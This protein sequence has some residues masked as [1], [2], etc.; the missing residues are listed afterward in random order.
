MARRA[1][2]LR[3]SQRRKLL[4]DKMRVF[5]TGCTVNVHNLLE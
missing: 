4:K 2:G 1:F 5:G 3:N